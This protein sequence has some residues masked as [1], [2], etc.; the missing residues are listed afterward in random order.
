MNSFNQYLLSNYYVSGTSAG[1]G[2]IAMKNTDKTPALTFWWKELAFSCQIWTDR[3]MNGWTDRQTDVSRENHESLRRIKEAW[4]ESWRPRDKVSAREGVGRQQAW[5]R[6]CTGG[7]TRVLIN[8][9][10]GD[11]QVIDSLWL[12]CWGGRDNGGEA[13]TGIC[14]AGHRA[15]VKGS[16]E[17]S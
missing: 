13:G 1:A 5:R 9:C 14:P 15:P 8:Q 3:W 16:K 10:S 4:P 2:D 7:A 11:L 6:S 12:E 17:H